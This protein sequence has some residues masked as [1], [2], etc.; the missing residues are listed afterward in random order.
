[1]RMGVPDQRKLPA[2]V[3]E[4]LKN[5]ARTGDGMRP[6]VTIGSEKTTR[7]SLASASD[8]TSPLGPALTTDSGRGGAPDW[9]WAGD[10]RSTDV[11]IVR[12]DA[13]RSMRETC[14]D[15]RR[16]R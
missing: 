7:I 4:I 12:I 3:G 13:M 9:A 10:G 14:A 5:G 8:A 11:T 16:H 15:R 6:S 1:M 2:T